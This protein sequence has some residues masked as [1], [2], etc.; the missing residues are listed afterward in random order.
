MV[1]QRATWIIKAVR[2]T[3][4][5]GRSGLSQREKAVGYGSYNWLIDFG[6]GSNRLCS[7]LTGPI[8]DMLG[9]TS[10]AAIGCT[11]AAIALDISGLRAK[12]QS[13]KHLN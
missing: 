2:F 6:S 7:D 10:V 8:L 12:S 4:I 3:R 11:Q 5:V 13:R 1:G 9:T